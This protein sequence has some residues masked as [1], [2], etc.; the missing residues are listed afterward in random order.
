MWGRPQSYFVDDTLAPK[1]LNKLLGGGHREILGV[2]AHPPSPAVQ[3]T[4]PRH[5][6][7]K[8]TKNAKFKMNFSISIFVKLY[9]TKH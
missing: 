4:S 7:S 1:P 9:I 3:V 8:I 6:M 2:V 5:G